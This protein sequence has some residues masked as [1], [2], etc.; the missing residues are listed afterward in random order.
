MLLL[1]MLL[2]V[3]EFSCGGEP[4]PSARPVWCPRGQVLD[5]GLRCA[6]WHRAPRGTR[7]E[8][9]VTELRTGSVLLTGGFD[10]DQIETSSAVAA[11]AS[12]LLLDSEAHEP[13][14]LPLQMRRAAHA[15][16]DLLD[17]RILLLGGAR[18]VSRPDPTI[19]EAEPTWELLELD[20]RDPRPTPVSGE[21]PAPR[22]YVGAALAPDGTVIF[23]GGFEARP[24]MPLAALD[25]RRDAWRL[26]PDLGVVTAVAPL[27][28][29]LRSSTWSSHDDGVQVIGLDQ[30]GHIRRYLFTMS[31]S[32]WT[33]LPAPDADA[34]ELLVRRTPDGSITLL[35]VARS[36]SIQLWRTSVGTEVFRP[37]PT[38]TEALEVRALLS[39][40]G[41]DTLVLVST[42]SVLSLGQNQDWVPLDYPPMGRAQGGY[43]IGMGIVIDDDILGYQHFPDVGDQHFLLPP[44]KAYLR[45]WGAT[46]SREGP[47]LMLAD[48]SSWSRVLLPTGRGWRPTHSSPPRGFRPT[49]VNTP[50]C[51]IGGAAR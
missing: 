48:E 23:G 28:L 47:T 20:D 16:V 50:M 3:A 37:L 19:Y 43:A 38:P 49:Q 14:V 25:A 8:T 15:A 1:P 30:H 42:S 17:G 35:A 45:A 22:V 34:A 41:P 46:P 40:G 12:A 27:P 21:L 6:G 18:S 10:R 2:L 7:R 36:G 13:L 39:P 51:S 31:S 29:I 9:S 33:T 24:D 26:S 11:Q 5:E 44:P 4:T 32:A